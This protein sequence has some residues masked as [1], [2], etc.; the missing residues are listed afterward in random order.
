MMKAYRYIKTLSETDILAVSEGIKFGKTHH[1]RERCRAIELSHR[2]EK[3][4]QIAYL[5]GKRSETIRD[6]FNDWESSGLC[7]LNIKP[8]RG[9]KPILN[10]K[11]EELIAEIKK[12]KRTA[13]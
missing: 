2:G 9:L 3:I 8:G 12:S 5:L 10:R 6:W 13:T 1:F 7:G 4:S 11:S